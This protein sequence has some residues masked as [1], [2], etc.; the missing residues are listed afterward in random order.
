MDDLVYDN[1]AYKHSVIGSMA[2]LD[3]ATVEDVQQFFK[4]YYAPNNAV[5]ALVGDLD[6]KETLAKVKKYFGAIPRQPCPQ[7]CGP[8]RAREDGRAA[9][10]DGG[11]AGAWAPL[12]SEIAWRIPEINS[13]DARCALSVQPASV[14]GGGESSRLYQEAREGQENRSPDRVRGGRPRWS[15]HAPGGGFR[16]AW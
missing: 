9:C 2:D 16:T 12:P 3:A 5:L 8:D 7:A 13:S 14:L 4:T 11:Q 6:T 10:Q 15:I 1:F